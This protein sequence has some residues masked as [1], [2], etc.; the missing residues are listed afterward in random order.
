MVSDRPEFYETIPFIQ[1][2]PNCAFVI[3]NYMEIQDFA[4]WPLGVEYLYRIIEKL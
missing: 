2:E 1:I 4:C 3:I